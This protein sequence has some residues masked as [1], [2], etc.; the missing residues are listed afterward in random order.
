MTPEGKGAHLQAEHALLREQVQL[1]VERMQ[2][3]EARLAKDRHN[4]S[5]PLSIDGLDRKTRNLRRK[6][7]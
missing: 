5:I 4:G 3:L 6:S 7:C 2:E 1:L